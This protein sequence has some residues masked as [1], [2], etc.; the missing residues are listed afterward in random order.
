[1]RSGLCICTG[2][3]N[4]STRWGEMLP[5]THERLEGRSFSVH[6]EF[7]SNSTQRAEMP[8]VPNEIFQRQRTSSYRRES[9][10]QS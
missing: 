5:Y 2:V 8:S 1:M 10:I 4:Y 3:G 7:D 6:G 9:M